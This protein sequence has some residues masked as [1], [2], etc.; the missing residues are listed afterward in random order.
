[1]ASPKPSAISEPAL[2][3]APEA[4]NEQPPNN[5]RP[6]FQINVREWKS[7][8]AAKVR[9]T[10][11]S[12]PREVASF[13]RN[14]AREISFGSREQLHKFY[15]PDLNVN[16]GDGIETFVEKSTGSAP[17]ETI[18]EALQHSDYNINENA[19]VVSYRNN[20]NKIGGTPFNHRDAWEIDCCRHG[21][22]V[23]LD[24]KHTGGGAQ[25]DAHKR[26]MYYGYRFEALCTKTSDEPVN[27]N[28]EFCSIARLRIGNH[29]IL[30]S[31]EIDCTGGDAMN[32][33][34]ALKSY[35]ELKTMR[36]A[37]S[38]RELCSMYRYRFPKY[39]LQ[40][41]LAGV[42]TIAL[43]LRT[44]SGE[45]VGVKR[46]ETQRLPREAREFFNQSRQPGY[47]DPFL[48]INFID[49][50]LGSIQR[51]CCE[52]PTATVSVRYDPHQGLVQAFRLGANESDLTH[53][54]A[55][56]REVQEE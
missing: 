48:S 34:N 54:I 18:I 7:H 31:S 43:G 1:M 12:E 4:S 3:H 47:W 35:I 23:F 33:E 30:L 17:V 25:N 40:S 53:R 2:P 51:V 13:S 10:H 8:S 44:D 41:Y 27:A 45:L 26:F 52:H 39:W 38:D 9:S 24:V 22:T 37:R 32:T 50:L 19:D 14:N 5:I 11:V 36:V 21:N 28:S 55:K 49:V 42:P 15:E 56:V 29:R 16:L 46:L 6:L 20:L